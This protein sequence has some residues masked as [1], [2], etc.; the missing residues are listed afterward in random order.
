MGTVEERFT[1]SDL[2]NIA[3]E[4]ASQNPESP[5]ASLPSIILDPA[6]DELAVT[7]V[8]NYM[9]SMSE[10]DIRRMV[11][12]LREQSYAVIY[13][14]TLIKNLPVV[15]ALKPYDEISFPPETID[16]QKARLIF[17]KVFMTELE[18]RAMINTDDWNEEGVRY[19]S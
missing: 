3:T 17:R 2:V 7:L 4:M 13:K 19:C 14:E 18:V 6:Q 12:E 16:L 9:P 15:T 1:I 10:K 11:K 8:A 5:L